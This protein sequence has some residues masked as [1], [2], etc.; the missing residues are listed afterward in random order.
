MD[1][2][3][4]INRISFLR[5]KANLS[6]RALSFAIGKNDSYINHL[7]SKRNFEPSLTTLFAIIEACGSTPE[8]FFYSDLQSYKLDLQ[9]IS[10]LKT[11]APRQ[12]EAVLNLYRT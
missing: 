7:E 1:L 4:V 10:M 9:L 8:E 6:A 12:K 3:E 11:L 5:T 2:N